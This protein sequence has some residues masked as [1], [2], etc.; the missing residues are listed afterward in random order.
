M[1][2]WFW[3]QQLLKS[4]NQLQTSVFTEL[5]FEEPF[6]TRKLN[7]KLKLDNHFM[8]DFAGN[9]A[10]SQELIRT[11]DCQSIIT[12]ENSWISVWASL[13]KTFEMNLSLSIC[14]ENKHRNAVE[15]VFNLRRIGVFF[16][17]PWENSANAP[18]L[19]PEHWSRATTGSWWKAIKAKTERREESEPECWE[20]R[21]I[22]P[23]VVRRHR[24]LQF[25]PVHKLQRI[26]APFCWSL[27]LV[28]PSMRRRSRAAAAAA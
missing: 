19:V 26:S 11:L 22:L 2:C 13:Q 25:P 15:F 20:R 27:L 1:D 28:M 10:A 14:A 18:P 21:K 12:V 23:C 17:F 8:Q 4:K 9:F 16:S 5:K 7:Q 6:L 3:L 24:V